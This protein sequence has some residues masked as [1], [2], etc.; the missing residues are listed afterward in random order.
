MFEH[1]DGLQLIVSDCIHRSLNSDMLYFKR[2]SKSF[3]DHLALRFRMVI[4]NSYLNLTFLY[5]KLWI[6]NFRKKRDLLV[7]F[8]IVDWQI[9]LVVA[10]KKMKDCLWPNICP[11]ILSPNTSSIVSLYLMRRI[12]VN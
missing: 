12:T 2:F 4:S 8:A 10:L 5:L 7:S 1:M 11:M 3:V 9:C 6:S